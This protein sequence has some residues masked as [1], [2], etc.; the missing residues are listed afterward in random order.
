MQAVTDIGD[1]HGTI[2][3]DTTEAEARVERLTEMLQD[4]RLELQKIQVRPTRP[5]WCPR[6]T[7]RMLNGHD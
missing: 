3:V 5:W 1:L 7:F 4:L 2:S 6:W